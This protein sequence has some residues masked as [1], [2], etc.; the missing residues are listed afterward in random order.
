MNLIHHLLTF[1]Q[2]DLYI[3]GMKDIL[4]IFFIST[5]FYALQ[6]WLKLDLQKNLL[7]YFWAYSSFTLT[8]YYTQAFAVSTIL[9]FGSPIFFGFLLLIHQHTLQKNFITLQKLQLPDTLSDWFTEFTKSTLAALNRQKEIIYVIEGSDNLSNFI[10]SGCNYFAEIQKDSMEL[11]LEKHIGGANSFIWLTHEGKLVA[12]DATWQLKEQDYW[13]SD[14]ARILH[15]WKQDA[16]FISQK[17]DAIICKINPINR[18][19]DIIIQGKL[20]EN[21]SPDVAI[22]VL[23]KIIFS[24]DSANKH[25]MGNL[26]YTYYQNSNQNHFKN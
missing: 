3:F 9:F 18:T 6:K 8:A 4:E 21:I 26:T 25:P 12:I 10:F 23:K 14:E 19:F 13:I 2:R 5:L 17:S 1:F 7:F 16:I 11:F 15:K 20:L 24:T 22:N